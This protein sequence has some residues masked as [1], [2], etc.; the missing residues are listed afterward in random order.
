MDV[1]KNAMAI[2]VIEIPFHLTLQR[3]VTFATQRAGTPT[4]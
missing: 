1:T 2:H 4:Y 3:T